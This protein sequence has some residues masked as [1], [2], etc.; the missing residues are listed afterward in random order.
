MIKLSRDKALSYLWTYTEIHDPYE[1]KGTTLPPLTQTYK[2]RL[3]SEINWGVDQKDTEAFLRFLEYS[4]RD[5]FEE[6]TIEL[7]IIPPK[8]P[9]WLD[10]KNE[11]FSWP[12]ISY[13]EVKIIRS[14]DSY[15]SRDKGNRKIEIYISKEKSFE[16]F[17][18]FY[19]CNKIYATGWDNIIKFSSKENNVLKESMNL[20]LWGV[21]NGDP[22]HY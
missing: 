4:T 7:S 2:E 12:R 18:R 8:T 17:S 6:M 3:L 15:I 10:D 5:D 14:E 20:V 9:R 13:S 19:I 21:I 11:Y 1:G 16:L 22:I